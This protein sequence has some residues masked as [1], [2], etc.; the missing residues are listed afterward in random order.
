MPSEGMFAF[1]SNKT[2]LEDVNEM[3]R[4]FPLCVLKNI[5]FAIKSS[6]MQ[7]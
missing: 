4:I 5:D 2:C 1:L 7:P 6:N 3:A